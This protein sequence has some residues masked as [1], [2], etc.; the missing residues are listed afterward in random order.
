MGR[1]I[2]KFLLQEREIGVTAFSIIALLLS[3][4]SLLSASVIGYSGLLGF[5]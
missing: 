5:I 4:I 1:Y 2:D 3:T